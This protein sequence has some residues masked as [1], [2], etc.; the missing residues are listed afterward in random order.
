MIL[1]FQIIPKLL[2]MDMKDDFC[3]K[4]VIL[5]FVTIGTLV[6][7]KIVLYF[8]ENLVALVLFICS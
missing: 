3:H 8:P 7:Q 6:F 2:P 1:A 4:I 5:N